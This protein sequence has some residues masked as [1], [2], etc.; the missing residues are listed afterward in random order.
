MSDCSSSQAHASA[1]DM[2]ILLRRC[3]QRTDLACRVLETFGQTAWKILE[4]LHESY[5]Q[6]DL[7]DVAAH[8]HSLKGAAATVAAFR[9]RKI[10][11][12][13][14][15]AAREHRRANVQLL[16][17]PL[18]SQLHACLIATERLRKKLGGVPHKETL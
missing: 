18:G 2:D 1:I 4:R 5:E 10:C 12:D 17:E 3:M 8:A 13:V 7:S 16:L 15:H 14:E 6:D 9:L 11:E